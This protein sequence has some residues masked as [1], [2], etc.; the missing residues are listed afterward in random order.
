MKRR[1]FIKKGGLFCGSALAGPMIVKSQTLGLSGVSPNNRIQ[2]ACIGNGLIMGGHRGYYATQ[3]RTE[4][5]AVCDV[6]KWERE[7][8]RDD[9]RNKSDA[10][11][12]MYEDFEELLLRDDIDAVV[13][14]TPDHWHAAI[15]IA[16]MSAGKD[17]YVEKPM[18]L[19]IAESKAM[20]VAQR[21]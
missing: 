4:V 11:P 8:A 2:I 6:K 19:T 14:G 13:V 3:D 17:V 16:A 1:S 12:D 7:D 18:T 20:V 21:R 10:I 15:S 5:V 9:V